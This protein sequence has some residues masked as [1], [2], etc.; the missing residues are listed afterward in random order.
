MLINMNNAAKD[1][2]R[3]AQIEEKHPDLGTFESAW[4]QVNQVWGSWGGAQDEQGNLLKDKRFKVDL[5]WELPSNEQLAED[6]VPLTLASRAMAEGNVVSQESYDNWKAIHKHDQAQK[7]VLSAN[8]EIVNFAASIPGFLLNPVNA[9]ELALLAF[10]GGTS[11]LARV[12]MGA[13]LAGVTAY[14]DEGI[15]QEYLGLYDEKAKA[16]ITAISALMGGGANLIFGRRI[17]NIQPSGFKVP[18]EGTVLPPGHELNLTDT[19]KVIDDNGNLVEFEGTIPEG[20]SVS[21]SLLGGMYSSP[22]NTARHLAS[23]LQVSGASTARAG[24]TFMGDTVQHITR[25]IQSGINVEQGVIKNVYKDSFKGMNEGK[26]NEMVYDGLARKNA[27]EVID[28]PLGKAVDAFERGLKHVGKSMDDV[29]MAT[30]A[31][32]LT[33]EWNGRIFTKKGRA[34]V[35]KIVKQAILNKANKNNVNKGLEMDARIAKKVTKRDAMPKRTKAGSA[36]RKAKDAITKELKALRAER[37]ALNVSEKEAEKQANHLYDS[38]TKDDYAANANTM[39]RRS[40]DVDEVD[41]VE[42]LNRNAGDILAK[43]SYRMSGRIGTKKVLGFHTEKELENTSKQLRQR[44]LDETGDAK[45]ADKVKDYFE[46]NVRLMWGT[47]MKS[48][49]PAWA[50]MMKKGV[51]DLNFATIGGGFAATAALG[52]LAL[53]IAMAGFRVGMRA[54][55]QSLRDFKRIYKEQPMDTPAMAKIQLAVHGFDK[56]NHSITTRV[57][58]DLEEGY[59]QT[60]WLNEKLA[61]ATEHV[62]NTLPLSTVTTA[63]RNAIGMSF[64]DDLF[65]NP[66]LL[67]ALDEY[68]ATGKMNA[69]LVKLTRLQFDV[70]KLRQVQA[71]ADEV[72]TW[73]GGARGK[74]KL[75]DYDL[76]VL[77]EDLNQMIDRG[78]SNASDLNIL[79]GEKQHLPSWW[80]NPNNVGLHLMTQFM[81]YPLHA[82]E[83]LLLRGYSERNAAMAVGIM[84]SAM[85]TGILS[86]LGEG[87]EIAT[88]IRREEDRKY[89]LSTTEGWQHITTRMLNTNSILAPLSVGLNYM[90]LAFTGEALGSNYRSRHWVEWLGGPT[91][92]RLQD[93]FSSV[94][95]LDMNPFDGNSNAWK[96]VYGRTI[97][98][99]SGLPLYT[100]PGV[101]DALNTLNKELAGK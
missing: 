27:G 19:F 52:E 98:M 17:G 70:T 49:L 64:L 62:S 94:Q 33:R 68:E 95:G 88:G 22:S 6:G 93:I 69:D 96:T 100:L 72:F 20:S 53:P 57:A 63:A 87:V 79:M 84:T 54:I 78:L 48:D 21:Y 41:V 76:T 66:R 44:V 74:G 83:S 40:I 7:E 59:Q 39:K 31:N 85:F 92:S 91:A 86:Y 89:D 71:K 13:S 47:Q 99:N 43:T 51:M 35:V 29:G 81:S 73:T 23:R 60:S 101:G 36:E 58:N 90:K 8:N 38:I 67:K 42:L 56:T 2:L 34:E 5:E 26:F 77:G 30:K 25:Q 28:G 18:E 9:P 14:V 50:Q 75:H 3:K 24:E 10:T 1:N 80:S 32:Y 11:A 37:R 15:R 12:A 97:M 82:Y 61:K 46:R 65:Y 4:G 16:D 45:E 55:R